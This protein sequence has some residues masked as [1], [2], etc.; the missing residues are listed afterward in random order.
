MAST[1][2]VRP[3]LDED[4]TNVAE[5]LYAHGAEIG[6]QV[7]PDTWAKAMTVQ[8]SFDTPNRGF[9]LVHHGRVVGVYVAFYSE[10]VIDGRIERFCNLATWCVDAN[11]RPHSIRLLKALLGQPG[12]HFTDLSPSERVVEI[13]RRLGFQELDA[14]RVSYRTLSWPMFSL[15]VQVTSAHHKIEEMLT[16]NDLAIYR[17][18]RSAVG[19]LQVVAAQDGQTCHLIFRTAR[20]GRIRKVP[21]V[22]LLYASNP[23]LLRQAIRPVAGH[24]LRRYGAT[25]IRADLRIMKEQHGRSVKLR[26][27]RRPRMFRTTSLRAEHVDYLYSE[28]SH[29]NGMLT[30]SD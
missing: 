14:S 13:N 26:N 1:V 25:E 29:V 28:L 3:V 16:G 12:Y 15:R 9:M 5:F 10:R 2:D 22:K 7:S 21:Y 6:G 24:L 11:Y 20:P 19:L 18:H 27:L 23:G 30:R 8:W 17:D 4:I